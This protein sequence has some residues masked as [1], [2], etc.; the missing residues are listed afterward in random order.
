MAAFAVRLDQRSA[1][2]EQIN[3]TP[4]VDVLLVLLIIFMIATPLVTQ[5]LALNFSHCEG[6]SVKG[7]EPV[8]LSIKRTGEL[9]WNGIAINR[10]ELSQNLAVL[11]Q[12]SDPPTFTLRPEASAKYDQVAE[13]LTAAKNANLERI[14]IEPGRR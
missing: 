9:Y 8:N 1:G 6:C 11:A 4:L 13:V 2:F 3:V 5:K 10:A 14:S 7:N 12:Q